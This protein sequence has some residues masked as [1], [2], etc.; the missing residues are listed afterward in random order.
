MSSI[1]ELLRNKELK[2][3]RRLSNSVFKCFHMEW[4]F[5]NEVEFLCFIFI[6]FT[7]CIP[8]SVQQAN[9]RSQGSLYGFKFD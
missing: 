6:I 3:K 7:L 4:I 8:F 5:V 2:L 1:Y 9:G